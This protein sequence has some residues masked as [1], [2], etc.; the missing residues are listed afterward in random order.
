MDTVRA[1]L[2]AV[3][4]E[5][6][7]EAGADTGDLE[8][9]LDQETGN[10]GTNEGEESAEE[11]ADSDGLLPFISPIYVIAMLAMAAFVIPRSKQED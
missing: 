4:E 6:L 5:A 10:E 7:E 2:S 1:E 11:V 3:V 9:G 8:F